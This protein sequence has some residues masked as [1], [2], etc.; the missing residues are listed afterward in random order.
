[1]FAVFII[2]YFMFVDQ[3]SKGIDNNQKGGKVLDEYLKVLPYRTF[4]NT[5]MPG[6]VCL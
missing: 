5:R 1:M 3:E 2:S 6:R 4:D